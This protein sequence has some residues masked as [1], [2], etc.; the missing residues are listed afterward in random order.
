MTTVAA[1]A[2]EAFSGFKLN[3]ITKVSKNETKQKKLIMMWPQY[4]IESLPN[5][6]V[7]NDISQPQGGSKHRYI[8]LME[9][10]EEETPFP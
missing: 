9:A 7:W 2:I 6:A 10:G 1:K 8:D 4:F 3:P 5:C